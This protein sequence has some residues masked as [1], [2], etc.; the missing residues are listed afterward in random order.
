MPSATLVSLAEYL[1]T[2]YRPDR[3]YIDGELFERNVG[4]WPHSRAQGRLYAFL[5]QRER[6]WGIRAVPEQRVQVTPT[7]FRIPDICVMLASD[8][9]PPILTN[10]P[11]LCIEIL[12]RDDTVSQLNERLADYFRFGV[13]YVGVIDPLA[14]RAFVY[15]PGHMHEV[16]DGVLRTSNPELLVPLEEIFKKE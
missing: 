6:E 5:F 15:T 12:S 8:P 11:F 3:D 9:I 16:L 1:A 14:R 2:T 7:R 13:P 4:D 10:A